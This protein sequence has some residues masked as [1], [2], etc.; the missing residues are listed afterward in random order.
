M[1]SGDVKMKTV[2]A[3]TL[4]FPLA[5]G[6]MRFTAFLLALLFLTGTAWPQKIRTEFY[7]PETYARHELWP[8][9]L[10]PGYGM[11]M[12][13]EYAWGGFY[14][15][16]KLGLWYMIA[17]TYNQYR[18]YDSVAGAA[19]TAQSG[20][21]GILYFEHPRKSGSFYSVQDYRNKSDYFF[22][23]LI[24]SVL[25]QTSLHIISYYHSQSLW[26][27]KNRKNQPMYRFSYGSHWED[28]DISLTPHIGR[29][30]MGISINKRIN[31]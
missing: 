12:Q 26:E 30:D 27:L 31:F 24:Y 5:Y 8:D 25:A 1:Q 29:E 15:I 18:F 17:Y 4:D 11:W 21:P 10:V 6:Y 28:G 20:Q 2:L 14:S 23:F 3:L 7:T 9:F 19:Y 16:S 13:K 22:L